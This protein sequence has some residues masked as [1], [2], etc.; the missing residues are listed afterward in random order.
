MRPS[1]AVGA[2]AIAIMSCA[3][4]GSSDFGSLPDQGPPERPKPATLFGA[5]S[6]DE[7]AAVGSAETSA[8]TD[9]GS[10]DDE[11]P[12]SSAAPTPQDS[13]ELTAFDPPRSFAATGVAVDAPVIESNMGG[14]VTTNYTVLHGTTAFV[15]RPDGVSAIDL[16]TGQQQWK[17]TVDH[18][19]QV[20][21][22]SGF[23][24]GQGPSAP[25]VSE[26]GTIV[27][28][29]F[30]TIIQGSGTTSDQSA[31]TVVGLDA[32]TGEQR[33]S[34]QSPTAL[35]AMDT[36]DSVTTVYGFNDDVVMAGATGWAAYSAVWGIADGAVRWEPEYDE[37]GQPT[38]YPVSFHDGTFVMNGAAIA[39]TPEEPI[40]GVVGYSTADGSEVW[41]IEDSDED[42]I[43]KE[44]MTVSPTLDAIFTEIFTG[45]EWVNGIRTFD[46]ATGAIATPLDELPLN[47]VSAPV[48]TFDGRDVSVCV[49]FSYLFAL[50]AT[51]GALLWQLPDPAQPEREAP[52]VRTAYHGLVY[53][54]S[55]NGAVILD[56][57]TGQDVVTDPGNDPFAVNEYGGL[58]LGESGAMFV[59]ATG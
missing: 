5:P 40:G 16:S 31:L 53:T 7:A 49:D 47:G 24:T 33:W 17:F 11:S 50:D 34:V 18:S 22:E 13:I 29:A 20:A 14:Q 2:A 52:T 9:A 37:Y 19:A 51:T 46:P 21:N 35:D 28:A 25:V 58:V 57:R 39:G 4:C 43:W 3:G 45:A 59:P 41:R 12:S 54:R 30:M 44:L 8:T 32:E 27:A 23:V 55:S 10:P 56:A 1:R 38:M 15:S 48:C 26:D 42:V 6:A 36:A